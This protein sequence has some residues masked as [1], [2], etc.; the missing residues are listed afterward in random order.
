M[1]TARAN[2]IFPRPV[3]GFRGPLLD[4]PAYTHIKD[5]K[6]LTILLA[7]DDSNMSNGGLEVVKKSHKMSVPNGEDSLY[8][9]GM[10]GCSA[11]TPVELEA[12]R[13]LSLPPS[14]RFLSVEQGRPFL[15]SK[16]LIGL[17]VNS[18][19]SDHIPPT[20]VG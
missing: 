2:Y 6:H 9:A 4:A 1:P 8:H 10:G 11:L 5:V 15:G 20:G 16:W 12:G 18:S 7:V 14:F 17:Q 3:G 19:F 13:F